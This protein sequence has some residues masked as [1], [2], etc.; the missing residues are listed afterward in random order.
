MKFSSG[1]QQFMQRFHTHTL[2]FSAFKWLAIVALSFGLLWF[3]SHRGILPNTLSL[4]AAFGTIIFTAFAIAELLFQ[5]VEQI[6]ARLS[7]ESNYYW[8]ALVLMAMV[9]AIK[10][11]NIIPYIV[12]FSFFM[13]ARGLIA[14]LFQALKPTRQKLK[15]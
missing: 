1:L 15:N 12:Q 9:I 10:H 3:T 11:P 4:F 6:A 7:H 8:A 5:C 14:G 13:L 2:S